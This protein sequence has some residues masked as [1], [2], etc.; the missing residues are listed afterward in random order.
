MG[1]TFFLLLLLNTCICIYRILRIYSTWRF[2]KSKKIKCCSFT[3]NTGQDFHKKKLDTLHKA[4]VLEPKIRKTHRTNG[5]LDISAYGNYPGMSFLSRTMNPTTLVKII[6][7]KLLSQ[8]LY[9]YQKFYKVC[10]DCGLWFTVLLHTQ[11][12][13]I[14]R[15]FPKWEIQAE[16]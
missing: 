13:M 2:M 6:I 5:R 16:N 7:V 12:G 9:H 4:S 10:K 8:Q 14:T 3:L 11:Y 1:S 15:I